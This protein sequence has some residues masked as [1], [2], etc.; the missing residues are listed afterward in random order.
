MEDPA[1]ALEAA[2]VFVQLTT[3]KF[4]PTHKTLIISTKC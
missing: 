1:F 4:K 2:F 3:E